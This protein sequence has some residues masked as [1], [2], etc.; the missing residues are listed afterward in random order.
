MTADAHGR[1]ASCE[2]LVLPGVGAFRA[3]AQQ[4]RDTGLGEVVRRE[5]GAGKPL[6]G[7][8]LGMQLLF[9]RSFEYGEHEGLGLLD[10]S[11]KPIAP[12]IGAGLKV[13]HIGRNALR[14]PANRPK[15]PLFRYIDEGSFV[16]FVHSYAANGLRRRRHRHRGIRRAARGRRGEGQDIRLPVPSGKIPGRVGLNILR[17]FCEI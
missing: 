15:S 16:Y 10:G 14:F 1:L 17:A 2:R 9:A 6:L 7:V 13:P 8:C 3:A 11:V 4:L 5:A 12:G